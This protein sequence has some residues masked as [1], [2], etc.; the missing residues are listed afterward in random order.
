MVD[1]KGGHMDASEILAISPYLSVFLLTLCSLLKKN[2]KAFR[3]GFFSLLICV[4]FLFGTIYIYKNTNNYLWNWGS[5]FFTL[6]F[7]P[8]SFKIYK[9]L[10]SEPPKAM[11]LLP[12][13]DLTK[14][15]ITCVIC[16]LIISICIFL[17]NRYIV[18]SQTNNGTSILYIVDNITGEL[19]TYNLYGEKI[20]R[21]VPEK[22]TTGI[23]NWRDYQ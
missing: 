5:I 11:E 17:S 3:I 20:V 9:I 15:C 18:V 1:I 16:S 21:R 19:K 13:K 23:P 7:I 6:Y 10:K 12:M 14:I 4:T 2:W 8:L 22:S